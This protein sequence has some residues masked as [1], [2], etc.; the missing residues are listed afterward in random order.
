MKKIKNKFIISVILWVIWIIAL[1]VFWSNLLNQE[2]RSSYVT[3]IEGSGVYSDT[4]NEY[5]L[6]LDQP[7]KLD[8]WYIVKTWE[9]TSL[10]LIEWWDGSVTRMW[11]NSMVQ[12]N[13]LAMK[14]DLSEIQ[15][16]F[17]LMQWKTWSNVISYL[18]D[19]SYFKETFQD[20]EAAVRGTVFN[21]DL[22][23][24]YLY[25][26][27]HEVKITTADNS[28][29]TVP[30]KQPLSLTSFDFIK[31]AEF[32]LKVKDRAWEDLNSKYDEEYL[33]KLQ[34][35]LIT[36]FTED[37]LFQH[38][39]EVL[40]ESDFATKI[41]E[42]SEWER[43]TLYDQILSDYQKV[44]S[45]TSE[46]TDLFAQKM[47]I[48]EVL[49][50]LAPEKE[51]EPLVRSTLYDMEEVVNN[52]NFDDLQ[53]IFPLLESQKEVLTNMNIELQDY[54]NLDIVPE[55][56][57]NILKNNF[58]ELKDLFWPGIEL[59][60]PDTVKTNLGN[61]TNGANDIVNQADSKVKNTLDDAKSTIENFI[62][63]NK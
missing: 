55:D 52:K 13:E 35:S 21:L 28:V 16:S 33:L 48:K 23:N 61:I 9:W 27:E 14:K 62:I 19:E 41:N 57:R 44:H 12:I 63:N 10:A 1:W 20:N 31:F 36:S 53:K 50:Q 59:F 7:I 42:M 39:N 5:N 2:D 54:I 4:L 11:P 37:N 18:W 51:K 58:Y 3:L 26:Q 25:V 47:Q 49:L 45:I 22:D 43:N 46:Q 8:L 6:D 38:F 56:L 40:K 24:E 34:E 15:V 17:E 29:I 60:N 30:E 32:I